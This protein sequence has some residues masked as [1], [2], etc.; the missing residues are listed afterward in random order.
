M[1]CPVCD[2][3]M[4]T[5]VEMRGAMTNNLEEPAGVVTICSKGHVIPE[6]VDD[7]AGFVTGDGEPVDD[8]AVQFTPPGGFPTR[9]AP[10]AKTAPA[11]KA[12]RVEPTTKS[13]VARDS[14]KD[15]KARRRDIA[16]EVKRLSALRIEDDELAA[17]ERAIEA[18]RRAKTVRPIRAEASS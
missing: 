14:L 16:R 5:R 1:Y 18:A 3:D 9:A 4:P 12:V 11:P 6:Q 13:V 7:L 17:A 8:V 10:K 15:I 2:K